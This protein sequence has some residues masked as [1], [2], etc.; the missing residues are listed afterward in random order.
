MMKAL[1]ILRDKYT[2]LAFKELNRYNNGS[3]VKSLEIM[4]KLFKELEELN[5]RSCESCKHLEKK[6]KNLQF[7]C[8]IEICRTCSRNNNDNFEEKDTE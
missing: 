6:E 4:N 8:L 1:G 3:A 7:E 5:N 2:S